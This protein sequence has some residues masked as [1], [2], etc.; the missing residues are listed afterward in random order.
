MR[1][2]GSPNREWRMRCR[3]P[4]IVLLSMIAAGGRADA[5]ALRIAGLYIR[6]A[7]SLG[8]LLIQP[9]GPHWKVSISAGGPPRGPATAADC[10]I[11]AEGDLRGTTLTAR[12][13]DDDPSV[14]RLLKMRLSPGLAIITLGQVDG[15]CG[16]GSD[17]SG[18]YVKRRPHQ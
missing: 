8:E 12:I 2:G 13:R 16:M 3:L 6:K 9:A 7:P 5:A 18:V 4:E 11:V 1:Q 15:L 10:S 17:V 14:E